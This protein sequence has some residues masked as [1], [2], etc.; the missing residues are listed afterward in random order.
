[1]LADS[2]VD[3]RKKRPAGLKSETR[4]AVDR[5]GYRLTRSETDGKNGGTQFCKASLL[6]RNEERST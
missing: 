2:V 5:R 3:G 6:G 1:M 4:F